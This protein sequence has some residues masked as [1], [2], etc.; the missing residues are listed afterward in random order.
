MLTLDKSTMTPSRL[1]CLRFRNFLNLE[2]SQS[3]VKKTATTPIVRPIIRFLSRAERSGLGTGGLG[4]ELEV[5]SRLLART[6]EL[7][8]GARLVDVVVV[9]GTPDEKGPV[10]EDVEAL[11]VDVAITACADEFEGAKPSPLAASTQQAVVPFTLQQKSPCLMAE[12]E[13]V[14][15]RTKRAFPDSTLAELG[16]MDGTLATG[17]AKR[18][19]YCCFV[20]LIGTGAVVKGVVSRCA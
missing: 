15:C 16:T 10:V 12:S 3:E 9:T 5:L 7:E 20:S 17:F 14:H 11:P 1:R 8:A 6:D 4:K 18:W 13:P 2:Y 19:A